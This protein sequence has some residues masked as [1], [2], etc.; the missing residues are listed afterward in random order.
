MNILVFQNAIRF[1]S[2][3]RRTSAFPKTQ[4]EENLFVFYN[5]DKKNANGSKEN[6]YS[7][8]KHNMSMKSVNLKEEQ[9]RY[10]STISVET[11]NS[12]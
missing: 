5:L 8:V 9:T 7:F 3:R 10:T 2:L 6:I 12:S 11:V 1:S 4:A